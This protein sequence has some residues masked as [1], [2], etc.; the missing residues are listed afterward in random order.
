MPQQIASMAEGQLGD[1][2]R[3]PILE[4]LEAAITQ[5]TPGL[6]NVQT[7]GD[8]Y[9]CLWMVAVLQSPIVSLISEHGSYTG[10]WKQNTDNTTDANIWKLIEGSPLKKKSHQR[11]TCDILGISLKWHLGL[12][13]LL[14]H[15]GEASNT[16]NGL[17]QNQWWWQNHI[18]LTKPLW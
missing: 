16:S 4:A 13:L 6:A 2:I 14:Q 10:T 11:R 9:A 18:T 1:G 8:T 3:L 15:S 7:P 12:W 5:C 17:P